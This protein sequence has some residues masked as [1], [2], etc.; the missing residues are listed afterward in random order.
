M[1]E[2]GS[3]DSLVDHLR[4]TLAAR[5]GDADEVLVHERAEPAHAASL[6]ILRP[7]LP[8]P[9]ALALLDSGISQLYTHQVAAVEHVRAGR[10]VVLASPTASGKSLAFALPTLERLLSEQERHALY[11]YPTKALI[12]DQ[13]RALRELATAIGVEEPPR[14]AVLTGDTRR[15]ERLTLAA[16]PP[17]ILLANPDILHH[18]LLPDHRRWREFLAGLEVVV[19]DEL[20]SYRGVF[21]AHVALV[22]RRLRRLAALY[23]ASPCFIAASATI[24]NPTELAEH[25]VGLPFVDVQ[26]DA[27]GA[28][29]RRFVFWR[30]P[31]RG[32]PDANEHESVLFEAATIFSEALRAGH[33]GILFGRARMSV[34]RMLLDV[35]RLVGT[36]LAERVS[37]YKSGYRADERARI[38]AGL[39][40]GRLR[41]VVSTNALELG[42][43]VGSL[44]LAVLAGYP[45]STMSFWQQAGRVGRRADREAVVVLVA[46]D[47]ALDQ[48]VIQHPEAFFGRAMEHA[49]VDPSNA[50]VQLGHLLCAASESPLSSDDM[51]LWPENA[52]GLVR[53]LAEAGELSTGEPWQSVGGA[54][55]ADV[56]LR[57]TSRSPY[58]LQVGRQVLGTIEPP[59][60][61]RECYPGA[62]YLHNGRAYRAVSLLDA[63]HVVQLEPADQDARTDPLLELDVAPRGEPL[64]S[65]DVPRGESRLPVTLTPL[66]VREHIVGYRERRQHQSLS[67]ALNQPLESVLDTIG[68]SIDLPWSLAPDSSSVHAF[69]HALVNALP[70]ALLC[71]RRDVGSS[72]EANRVYIYDFAEGG[73]GLADK[74]FHLLETL[75]ERAAA[76]VRDCPCS[77]GCPNCLH[78]SGCA[79]ANRNLDKVGGLAL[80][81]GRSVSAARAASEVLRGSARQRPARDRA[82]RRRRLRDIADADVRARYAGYSASAPSSELPTGQAV[83][84]DWL[85]PGVLASD[86]T[87]G[88]VVVWDVGLYGTAEVQPLSGGNVER[89]PV[90]GLSPPAPG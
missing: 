76:L 79:D 61:Q 66:S 6:G 68:V 11:L 70:L 31:L 45:G 13:L 33:S 69:E 77:E 12:G 86:P 67:F 5:A 41:G 46:G 84:P 23:R 25:V 56:S 80:L 51:K 2:P 29:P 89:V 28:G 62:V 58:S 18:S 9:L 34:E 50:A 40:S 4:Q 1:P 71:D 20:H 55:H 16:H 32:D 49:A 81:L 73:I 65:R 10:N 36:E 30:P 8:K 88:L 82:E 78:L 14:V 64:A 22:L 3:A 37:A 54:P 7:H 48:Y 26:G 75:F 59:W 47:D 74:A 24:S 83:V 42:I 52:V 17:A 19:L 44:D 38:E 87:F 21:G 35:R 43:D 39:R 57:G 60:L 90:S 72:S 27:A 63:A 53:R 85:Q 15:D